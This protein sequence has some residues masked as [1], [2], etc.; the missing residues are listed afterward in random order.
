MQCDRATLSAVIARLDRTI[1]YSRDAENKSKSRG[2]LDR[3]VTPDD[4]GSLWSCDRTTRWVVAGTTSM[5]GSRGKP[6]PYARPKRTIWIKPRR[7]ASLLSK[8]LKK[9]A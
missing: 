7:C 5:V 6:S 1:Q 9:S 2:V 8:R 4:D 3:P